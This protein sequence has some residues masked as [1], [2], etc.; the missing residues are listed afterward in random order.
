M[1]VPGTKK[2][3][4]VHTHFL[5]QVSEHLANL[6]WL[7]NLFK[8][9]EFLYSSKEKGLLI[10]RCFASELLDSKLLNKSRT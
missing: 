9:K 5:L 6:F 7:G 4:F 10:S 1:S 2:L 3:F 8:E